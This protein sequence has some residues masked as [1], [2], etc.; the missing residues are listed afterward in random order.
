VMLLTTAVVGALLHDPHITWRGQLGELL[1]LQNYTGF[2]WSHTWSLAVE[3]HFYLGLA[4]VVGFLVAR[5]TARRPFD[6]IPLIF[7]VVAVACLVLR[8]MTVSV[9]PTSQDQGVFPTHLRVDSLLF[10]VLL[11][12]LWHVRG[13]RNS[14]LLRRWRFA[15]VA[16]GIA[17]ITPMFIWPIYARA[18]IPTYGLT[19]VYLGCGLLLLGVLN[20]QLDGSRTVALLAAIGAYSYSIY[21]WHLAVKQWVVGQL[22]AHVPT[23]NW[24]FYSF[25]YFAGAIVLGV[26]M[27]RLIEYPVLRFRDRVYP[28]ASTAVE[29]PAPAPAAERAAPSSLAA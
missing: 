22:W 16:A 18:W 25:V 9:T 7:L 28:S 21:L 3:E 27:A 23:E 1:F 14:P 5:R 10:G 24:F 19:L 11:S 4:L 26:A 13:L 29:R 17:L 12:Y 8:V 6:A 15:L 20:M 2:V